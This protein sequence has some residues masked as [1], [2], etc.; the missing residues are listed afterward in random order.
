MTNRLSAFL[1]SEQ[2]VLEDILWGI[3]VAYTACAIPWMEAA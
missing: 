1:H 2:G 3:Q